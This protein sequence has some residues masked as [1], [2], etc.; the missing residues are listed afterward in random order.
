M[1]EK[2]VLKNKSGDIDAISEEFGISKVL[3]KILINKG[4]TDYSEIE[5]FLNPKESDMHSWKL[6]KDMQGAV[7]RLQKAIDNGEHI[8]IVGDYDVDGVTSTYLL[9]EALETLG[10]YVSYKI[11]DR[12]TDGYGIS[13]SIIDSMISDGTD[14]ILT[15]DN[16]I[17]AV[18]QIRYAKEKGMSVIVTDHHEV[19]EELPPADFI[20]DPK[21]KDCDYPFK[22]ICGAVVAAK[23]CEGLFEVYGFGKFIEKYMEIIALATVCDV[24]ELKDE[25][26]YIVKKGL[27]QM[28]HT[29][30]EGLK[31]LIRE[32]GIEGKPI[33]VY[34]L[35]FVIGPCLNATGR[36]ETAVAGVELLRA[37]TPKEAGPQAVKLTELNETR[38]QMTV[39]AT[40][41]AVETI[42]NSTFL[43]ESILMVYLSGCHESLA[44]IVAGRVRE[45]FNRPSIILTDSSADSEILKGS[46]RSTEDYNMYEGLCGVSELMLKFGGHKGAAGLSIQR[47]NLEEIRKKLNENCTENLAEKPRKVMI[48]ISMPCSGFSVALIEELQKLEPTG[49]GNDRPVFAD[50]GVE[51]TR[52]SRF[53]R[54]NNFLRIDAKDSRG[55]SVSLKLFSGVEEFLDAFEEAYGKTLLSDAF[56][57][58][59]NGVSFKMIYSPDIS[60]YNGRHV[61]FMLRRYSFPEN[62]K[63]K[64]HN[65]VNDTRK[66]YIFGT[67]DGLPKEKIIDKE[68]VVVFCDAGIK[69][70][71]LAES[72]EMFLLGD[73]DSLGDSGSD[74]SYINEIKKL[75]TQALIDRAEI[76]LS[77]KKYQVKKYP[78]KKDDTDTGLALKHALNLGCEKIYMYGC[79]GNE[80]PDHA[81]A[82]ISLLAYASGHTVKNGKRA[83][84]FMYDGRYT[85]TM[86]NGGSTEIKDSAG[87]RFAI[88]AYGGEAGGVNLSGF[89]YEA[90]NLRLTPDM[91]IGASNHIKENSA[92]ITVEWGTVLIMCECE[93]QFIC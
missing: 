40:E 31:A 33:T 78:V 8:C 71:A 54:E 37:E 56:S 15:C 83:Q 26:R 86:I 69:N 41:K 50:S 80:R 63:K 17:S 32:S 76:E 89:E 12:I 65:P 51:I 28:N 21:Q 23:L 22:G 13:M 91:T 47:S 44:G 64:D 16:G 49:N 59:A 4:M 72:N 58:K 84:A 57:G 39:Q 45:E 10:A 93:P 61:E 34:S 68:S 48:D 81:F 3:A 66:A 18:E 43:N 46:G 88:F 60:D 52:L 73:F 62:D 27:E 2:W 70:A 25:N 42:K 20:V 74:N 85:Y 53:G 7:G 5:S 77:G 9:M 11:P 75:G 6:M 30:N 35:G 82:N 36:L 87:K 29:E 79:V 19:P 24:M 1:K 67:A 14:L 38:K 55:V 92:R 90:E